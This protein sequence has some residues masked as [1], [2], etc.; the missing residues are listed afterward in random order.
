MTFDDVRRIA[1]ALAET[2]EGAS[3]GT[4]AFRVGKRLM[5]RQREEEGILAIRVDSDVK[6]ALMSGLPE[7]YFQ[8][9]HYEG[10]AWFLIRLASIGED[11]LRGMLEDAWW[12]AATPRI[13]KLRVEMPRAGGES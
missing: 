13:R 8:T 1:T 9:P 4:P 10:Y 7:I 3:H 12:E 11:E 2:V 6:E 5:C